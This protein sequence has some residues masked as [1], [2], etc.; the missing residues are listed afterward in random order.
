LIEIF[1]EDYLNYSN[2]IRRVL[3]KGSVLRSPLKMF[4]WFFL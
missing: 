4:G 3:S 1:R 2:D